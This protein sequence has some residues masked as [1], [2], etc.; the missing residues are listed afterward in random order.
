MKKIVI[1]LIISLTPIFCFTQEAKTDKEA[2]IDLINAEVK[3]YLEHDFE[4][5]SFCW[6][7][8]PYVHHN[9]T[10]SSYYKGL[11]G[12]DALK[13]SITTEFQS[14]PNPDFKVEKSDFNVQVMGNMA[15]ANFKE[16]Y[17]NLTDNAKD[18]WV[19]N[20]N[21]VFEKQGDEW[22]IVGYN[23]VNETTFKATDYDV[24]A[25]LNLA[26]N[27]LMEMNKTD[28]A[29]RVFDLC[30]EIQPESCEK[31]NK[32][33]EVFMNMGKEELARQYFKKCLIIE[34][35]NEVAIGKI[36]QIEEE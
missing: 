5:W 22:K 11:Q 36:E 15:I 9:Y 2:I 32:L 24:M 33:G 12:W 23:I 25:N 13:N 29:L 21:A 16:T 1:F 7:H 8:E 6:L 17:R 34:P 4:L 28:E 31:Y 26:G 20:N 3:A 14:L 27:M 19:A 18:V 30:M 35:K 10:T